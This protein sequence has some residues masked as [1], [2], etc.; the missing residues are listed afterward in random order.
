M[1]A[2]VPNVGMIDVGTLCVCVLLSSMM[3]F[4]CSLGDDK[5][6]HEFGDGAKL[7]M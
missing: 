1:S 7:L 3:H 5:S 2:T 4:I 6:P